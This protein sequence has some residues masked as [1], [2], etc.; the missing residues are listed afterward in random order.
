MVQGMG[1]AGPANLEAGR[2]VLSEHRFGAIQSDVTARDRD[3]IARAVRAAK[4]HSL[5][6]IDHD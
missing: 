3:G 4:H 1:R 5:D 6:Q 2:L